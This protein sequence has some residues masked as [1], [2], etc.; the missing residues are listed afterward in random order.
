MCD[1]L[2]ESPFGPAAIGGFFLIV[3][4]QTLKMNGNVLKGGAWIL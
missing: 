2:P 1:F 3:R 4:Q